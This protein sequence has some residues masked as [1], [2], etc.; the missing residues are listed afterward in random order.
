MAPPSLQAL[1]YKV[2]LWNSGDLNDGNLTQEDADVLNPW[3]TLI[4][5][6][7]NKLYL[8]GDGIV[9][10]TTCG[11]SRSERGSPDRR[12]SRGWGSA[13][14]VPRGPTVSRIVRPTECR[15]DPTH[16]V[17]LQPAANAVVAGSGD[18]R[19]VVHVAQGNGCPDLR[20]FDVLEVLTPDFG[21]AQGDEAYQTS[22]KAARFA[23]VVTDAAPS[24]ILNYK[25]VVDGVSLH[26]RRDEGTPC[27]YGQ[28]G[29]GAVAERLEEV[30]TYFGFPN[31]A[32]C[33]DRGH[34]DR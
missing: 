19:E 6:D 9:F 30:L 17:G 26:F 14:S 10:S 8:S 33:H 20:S 31:S 13:P 16:C 25:I 18:G 2:I 29:I 21:V 22:L 5:F 32:L 34:R 28:G 27:S 1:G 11:G 24:D 4:D 23:S 15:T 7:F 12:I 3:L